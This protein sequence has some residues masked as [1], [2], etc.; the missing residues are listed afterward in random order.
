VRALL[1]L[2]LGVVARLWLATLRVRLEVHPELA[3]HAEQPWVLAFFHGT[4]WP[5]LAWRRRR[6]TLVMV[7]HSAD[8]SMQA[9]ALGVLGFLVVR[10]SS[11]RGGA[12][13]LAA[14]VRRIRRGDVDAAFAV[15]GPRGPL[16]EVKPGAVLAA[17]CAG[18]VLV[19][20][21]SAVLRGKTFT[22]AWDRFVLAWPF[23]R[24]AVVLGAPLAPSA[25]AA[26]RNG[27][28]ESAR[29]LAEA[30]G[31]ANARALAMLAEPRPE[32]LPLAGFSGSAAPERDVLERN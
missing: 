24:V 8:G 32:L 17:R 30:I 9:R 26:E 10:G 5:L 7:S 15:D 31:V 20:M 3:R 2:A 16:G 19:P 4:Q 28:E 22:R 6:P 14:I 18:G 23:A 27:D 29:L 21:G 12:R 11:S 13:A 25:G 1:G